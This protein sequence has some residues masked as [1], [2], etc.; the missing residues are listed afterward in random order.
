LAAGVAG[1]ALGYLLDPPSEGAAQTVARR[2]AFVRATGAGPQVQMP[3]LLHY[4][5]AADPARAARAMAEEER[6]ELALVG[7]WTPAPLRQALRS[8]ER[9]VM[10]VA[11]AEPPT[12]APSVAPV[13]EGEGAA[14][15]LALA[16][17]VAT[18]LRVPVR[19]AAA[20]HKVA[21]ASSVQARV[22]FEQ[23]ELHRP[24]WLH[25]EDFVAVR[26]GAPSAGEIV[27][28]GEGTAVAVD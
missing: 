20:A 3:C 16:I 10:T 15:R 25:G 13:L 5:F 22:L 2:R 7:A 11:E 6:C 17:H 26:V 23:A 24:L 28:G 14:T 4:A 21:Q 27:V 8:E 12:A 1:V 9:R 19:L 18:R